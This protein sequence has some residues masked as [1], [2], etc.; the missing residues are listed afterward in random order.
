M[1]KLDLRVVDE[2]LRFFYGEALVPEARELISRLD[3]MLDQRERSIEAEAAARQEAERQVELERE[4][5]LA[6]EARAAE[7]SRLREEE[8]R[9]REEE[10]RAR[11]ALEL[12]VAALMAELEGR[13]TSSES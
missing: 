6:A 5:R 7:E 3:A 1:L 13:R 9:L 12:R 11:A 4:A 8:S 10:S 2:R